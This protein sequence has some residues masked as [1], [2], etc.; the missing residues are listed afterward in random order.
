MTKCA[1]QCVVYRVNKIRI[2]NRGLEVNTERA[3]FVAQCVVEVKTNS[4][5]LRNSR[6]NRIDELR[7][8][9]ARCILRGRARLALSPRR[10]SFPWIWCT[11]NF[12]PDINCNLDYVLRHNIMCNNNFLTA[13][14]TILKI[15]KKF[16]ILILFLVKLTYVSLSSLKYLHNFRTYVN[17]IPV[18]WE[19]SDGRV[20]KQCLH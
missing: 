1:V 11:S 2:K 4:R 5:R 13:R 16:L 15:K 3:L 17:M 19:P 20:L 12:P 6:T 10:T 7:V 9:C 14:Y 18:G 8:T